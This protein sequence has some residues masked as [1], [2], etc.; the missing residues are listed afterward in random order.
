MDSNGNYIDLMNAKK[1]IDNKLIRLVGTKEKLIDDPLRILRAIR[2]ATILN[3]KI[4]EALEKEIEKY[5]YLIEELSNYKKNQE[6]NKILNSNNKEYGIKLIIKYNLYKYLDIIDLK[7]E[8][9]YNIGGDY[10]DG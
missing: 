7:N 4:D 2:F 9:L 10:Y 6:I 8:I 5:G 3:F 1:D